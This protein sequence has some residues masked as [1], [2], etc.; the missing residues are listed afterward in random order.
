MP[1]ESSLFSIVWK[2]L[3]IKYK[4][5]KKEWKSPNWQ[6]R[7]KVISIHRWHIPIYIKFQWIL[8]KATGANKQT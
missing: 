2:I 4:K 8:K 3:A 1:L 6:G 5:V 7:S